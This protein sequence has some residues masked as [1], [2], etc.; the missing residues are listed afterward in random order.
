MNKKKIIQF[1]SFWRKKEE[2]K[3]RSGKRNTKMYIWAELGKKILKLF[4]DKATCLH[5]N[6]TDL[7][8]I[9]KHNCKN[10]GEEGTN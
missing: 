2:E 3:L 10:V 1:L 9:Y 4:F 8:F 5:M 6:D 7:P